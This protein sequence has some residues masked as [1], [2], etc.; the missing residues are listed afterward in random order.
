MCMHLYN[1]ISVVLLV[2]RLTFAFLSRNLSHG[3]DILLV[4]LCP[5]HSITLGILL[6]E[7]YYNWHL[8]ACGLFC[9]A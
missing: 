9:L 2:P 8:Y 4:C 5:L 7:T 6:G 3:I 1:C